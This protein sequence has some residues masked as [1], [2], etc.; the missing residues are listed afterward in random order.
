MLWIG[1]I[2]SCLVVLSPQESTSAPKPVELSGLGTPVPPPP[3]ATAI[4]GEVPQEWNTTRGTVVLFFSTLAKSTQFDIDGFATLD[5]RNTGIDI[6]AVSSETPQEIQALLQTATERPRSKEL[7]TVLSDPEGLWSKAILEL[8][9][10]K[11]LPVA[12]AIDREG[13]IA[14]HGIA[15][16]D[17]AGFAIAMISSNRWDIQ[18][19]INQI[20]LDALRRR[21]TSRIS[22][23]RHQARIDGDFQKA[24]VSI[25]NVIDS[26]PKN[27]LNKL[28][29]YEFMMVD[30][31]QPE[32]AYEYGHQLAAEYHND[33]ITLNGLAWRVVSMDL[34]SRD[35]DY[36]LEISM[37]ANALRSFDDYAL[38]DTL[39]RIHW[40][41]GDRERAIQWQRKSVALAPDTW[42]GDDARKNL[43]VYASGMIEPG[44]MPPPYSSPRKSR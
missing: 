35:L 18:T 2:L 1:L 32:R 37:K 7:Q 30:M 38:L 11:R 39:A 29:R 12:V 31:N 10:R 34:R 26:D 33:Y 27:V 5:E 41:R 24:M 13:R 36:A 42:H 15:T 23:A 14:W 4:I 20:D 40:M 44:V 22:T 43:S 25:D 8:T 6:I 19:Y 16:P 21:N 17:Y 28:N 3:P 9:N